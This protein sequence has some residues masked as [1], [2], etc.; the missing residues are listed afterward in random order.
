MKVGLM[1]ETG[2]HRQRLQISRYFGR[3]L[4]LFLIGIALPACSGIQVGSAE[5]VAAAEA[6]ELSE[7]L[8]ASGAALAAGDFADALTLAEQAIQLAPTNMTAWEMYRQAFLAKTGN[9]YL[10]GLPQTRYRL[11]SESFLHDEAAGYHYFVI[12]VREPDEYAETHINGAVNL[13]LRDLL[14]Y[15]D[16]LPEDP[17]T[18]ILVYC[19]SQKRSTHALVILR[20]L[21][22]SQVYN[23]AGGYLAYE[24]YIANNPVPAPSA[25]P[26]LT[27]A[28]DQPGAPM[29]DD[30]EDYENDC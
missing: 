14:Q 2:L 26:R 6:T 7:L 25:I 28:P 22:Y 27:P 16:E 23:L 8:E 30:E 15:P 11:S 19:R 1:A 4:F 10:Q 3:C 9:D 13:P 24:E 5:Q 21:G 18:P 29:H 20:Q 17:N 12:D